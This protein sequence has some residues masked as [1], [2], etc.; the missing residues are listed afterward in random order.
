MLMGNSNMYKRLSFH[1]VA[2]ARYEVLWVILWMNFIL[3]NF[4]TIT[5]QF[6]IY[7]YTTYILK[8]IIHIKSVS[9]MCNYTFIL[10]ILVGILS[11]SIK[12]IY[13]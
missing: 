8:H 13:I 7:K 9:F 12:V 1:T 4:Y 6:G 11:S 2:Y 10:C 5:M 3:T